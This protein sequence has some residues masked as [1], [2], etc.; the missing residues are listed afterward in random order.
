MFLDVGD[1]MIML[2]C[3]AKE[4]ARHEICLLSVRFPHMFCET[5][6]AL[7]ESAREHIL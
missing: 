1:A 4:L 7:L 3:L 6:H 2:Y 5:A